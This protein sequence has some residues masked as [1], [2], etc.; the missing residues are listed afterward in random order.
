MGSAVGSPLTATASYSTLRAVAYVRSGGRLSPATSTGDPSGA[1][2][3]TVTPT[4]RAS[5]ATRSTPA[6]SA[7]VTTRPITRPATGLD[8]RSTWLKAG[9]SIPSGAPVPVGTGR[10]RP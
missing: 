5:A 7:E 1:I 6:S 8:V 10:P 9:E 2:R 3:R 4:A